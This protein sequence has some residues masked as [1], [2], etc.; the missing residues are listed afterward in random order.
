M[1]V[2][3]CVCC[4]CCVCARVGGE[5][6]Q[7]TQISGCS[8]MFFYNFTTPLTDG[9]TFFCNAHFSKVPI[10]L[11]FCMQGRES[12]SS[13]KFFFAQKTANGEKCPKMECFISSKLSHQFLLEMA[14][15]SWNRM[16]YQWTPF[17]YLGRYCFSRFRVQKTSFDQIA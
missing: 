2:Y 9:T 4:M 11:N 1:Y 16:R 7:P 3:L 10:F 17:S 14:K 13:V 8:P 15:N 12:S 6:R 5:N